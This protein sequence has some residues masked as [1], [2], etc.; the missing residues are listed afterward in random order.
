[1]SEKFTRITKFLRLHY[2][3]PDGQDKRQLAAMFQPI[4][5]LFLLLF[6]FMS[7]GNE[8]LVFPQIVYLFF[9]FLGV[10]FAINAVARS[11]SSSPFLMDLAVT[12]NCFVIAGIINY[13]GQIH[14]QLWILFLLPI[15]TAAGLLRIRHLVFT[16]VLATFFIAFFYGNPQEWD[17]D[18]AFEIISKTSLLFM[19]AMLMRSMAM[20]KEKIALE[21]KVKRDR[22]DKISGEIAKTNLQTL[23]AE[24]MAEVGKRTSTILHDIST[25]ITII[26][27]SARMAIS[28]EKPSKA[29]LQRIIDAAVI[30]KNIISSS[31]AVAKGQ[32]YKFEPM[33]LQDAIDAAAKIYI[34]VFDEKKITYRCAI[35]ENLPEIRGSFHHLARVFMNF[36]SNAKG[37]MPNGGEFTVTAK[38]S[39]DR[40]QIEVV[41]EDSGPGFPA[42]LIANGPQMFVTTKQPGEGTG[43]G[44]AGSKEILTR[45]GAQLKLSNRRQGGARVTIVMPTLSKASAENHSDNKQA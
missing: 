43:L 24:G 6:I 30:C 21:L 41:V 27:G 39:E 1:M 31:M 45:H 14:S 3:G 36:M 38:P 17:K 44:L 19:G 4:F 12:A 35:E 5:L 28:D 20:Q 16:C 2:M 34:P 10:N 15:F 37:A 9:I 23:Q 25:P 7:R 8:L 11:A 13:S 26:L 40:Q 32:D 29:D 22:L 18:I 33:D 42:E